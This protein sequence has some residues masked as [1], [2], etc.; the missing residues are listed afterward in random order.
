MED[1]GVGGG[2]SQG[3]GGGGFIGGLANLTALSYTCAESY[4][5]TALPNLDCNNNANEMSNIDQGIVVAEFLG[6]WG[7]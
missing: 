6:V 1:F 7:A 4:F 3:G 2:Y 5:S